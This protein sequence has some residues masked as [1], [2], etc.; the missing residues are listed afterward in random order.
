MRKILIAS[1]TALVLGSGAALA[2]NAN[3]VITANP[4]LF[5]GSQITETSS[6]LFGIKIEGVDA[7]GNKFEYRFRNDGT[8]KKSETVVNG[9]QT[10]TRYDSTGAAVSTETS[11][12]DD[13]SDDS[14][15]E[16]DSND[17]NSS[18]SDSSDDSSEHS[19]GSDDGSDHDSG[20]DHDSGSDD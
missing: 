5:S 13:S 19:S 2:L 7:N 6:G 14:A 8:M 11:G 10:E 17:D 9:V 18:A 16:D 4:D 1:A 20:D 15:S 3:D 12:S